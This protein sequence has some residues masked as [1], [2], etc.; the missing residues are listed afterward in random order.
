[1]LPFLGKERPHKTAFLKYGMAQGRK[2]KNRNICDKVN[3]G[4]L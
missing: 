3:D 1:M 4:E 2:A